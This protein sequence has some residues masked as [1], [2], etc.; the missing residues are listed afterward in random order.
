DFFSDTE[1]LALLFTSRVPRLLAVLITGASLAVSGALMQMLVRNRFVEPMT[2]GSGQGAVLGILIA[3]LVF[4]EASLITKMLL[5]IIAALLSNMLFLTIVRRLPMGEPVLVPLAGLA[6]GGVIG[7]IVTFIAYQADLLQFIDIWVSG[8]FSGILQG[9]YELLWLA[10]AAAVLSYL[11]ADQFA[12]I[13][14]GHTATTNLGL[15]YHQTVLLGLIAIAV[16]VAITVVTVGIIPFIGLVVPNIISRMSG[17]NLRSTLP[18][19]AYTGAAL[20]LASDIL[21]RVLRYPFEI[22]VATVLGVL[23]SI[24]FIWLLYRPSPDAR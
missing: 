18:T 5:A 9:R 16:V 6:Y 1:A 17:D 19:I 21:A 8:E 3:V 24:V 14:M 11:A 4:P 22:P 12:I 15:N 20:V 13:G 2:A 23:G 7:A 10:G